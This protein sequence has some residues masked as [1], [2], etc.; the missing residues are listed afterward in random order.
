MALFFKAGDEEG[1][2]F[3]KMDEFAQRSEGWLD[4]RSCFLTASSLTTWIRP[5]RKENSAFQSEVEKKRTHFT[6]GYKDD[7]SPILSQ[8][9][10]WGQLNE[11][12]ALASYKE[13]LANYDPAKMYEVRTDTHMMI[14]E[15]ATVGASPDG[16]I[17]ENGNL[18]GVV[19]IKCPVGRMFVSYAAQRMV[20]SNDTLP[21]LWKTPVTPGEKY[22]VSEFRLNGKNRNH[23][24]QCLA[25]L[26]ISG[27]MWCDYFVW[28]SEL[29]PVD[30]NNGTHYR[31]IKMTRSP[32]LDAEWNEVLKQSQL[33]Y[34]EKHQ[35]FTNNITKF[36][37]KYASTDDTKPLN[38]VA[39]DDYCAPRKAR[40]LDLPQ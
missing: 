39:T 17:Y 9:F 20:L 31:V 6:G 22:N 37:E 29:N 30:W 1:S 16:L 14:D 36:L 2:V 4:L 12:N 32:E 5:N 26:Y 33:A 10:K 18:V 7:V 15:T 24:V 13:Y 21:T 23:Y 8:C 28:T 38:V 35:I 3:V 11:P 40:R 25:N 34:A 19:E 27:A